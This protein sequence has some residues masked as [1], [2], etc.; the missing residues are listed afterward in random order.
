[1]LAELEL[2]VYFLAWYTHDP[3]QSPSLKLLYYAAY[4]SV[5]SSSFHRYLDLILCHVTT[6]T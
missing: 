2:K 3:I 1:M 5:I 4:L 6:L